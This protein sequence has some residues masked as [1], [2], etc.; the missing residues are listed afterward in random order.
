MFLSY[1]FESFFIGIIIFGVIWGMICFFIAQRKERSAGVAFFMG[2]IFGFFA[3]LYYIFC[4]SGGKVCP[5][6]QKRI[7]L[8]AEICPYCRTKFNV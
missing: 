8:K 2:L 1:I 6:C 7:S 5:K 4:K 3:F